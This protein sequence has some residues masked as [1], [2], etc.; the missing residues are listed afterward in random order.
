MCSGASYPYS[1]YGAGTCFCTDSPPDYIPY[2]VESEYPTTTALTPGA[3]GG[4]GCLNTGEASYT[5]TTLTN[6]RWVLGGCSSGGSWRLNTVLENDFSSPVQ[7]LADCLGAGGKHAQLSPWTADGGVQ[8]FSCYC[9]LEGGPDS[10]TTQGCRPSSVLFYY[11]DAVPPQPSND[12]RG[13]KRRA[14]R[15]ESAS[16]CPGS[17]RACVVPGT[18]AYECVDTASELG[19]SLG[20]VFAN[21]RI[22][23]R[24]HCRR[25]QLYPRGNRPRVSYL[26]FCG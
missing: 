11:L 22:V 24:V 13:P 4:G 19:A 17:A 8:Q 15:R 18:Q 14:A 16:L 10:L 6:P 23:R 21:A 12:G 7:C 3:I 2:T 9:S 25:V 20:G 1:I 26:S 5:V